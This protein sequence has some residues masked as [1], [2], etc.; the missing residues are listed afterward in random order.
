MEILKELKGGLNNFMINKNGKVGSGWKIFGFML[1][2]IVGLLIVGSI[3]GVGQTQVEK[4]EPVEDITQC[5][6]S[7]GVLTA[8]SRSAL[9]AGTDPSSPTITAGVD[10]GPVTTSVTSGTTT[11]PVGSEIEVLVSKSD[12]IDRSFTFTMP[13]GGKT[14][15]APLFYSTSDNPSIRIKNDDGDFMTDSFKGATNQTDLSVGETLILDVE[16]QGTNGESSGDGIYIIEFPASTSANITSVTLDGQSP[17]P[18]PSGLHTAQNADSELVAFNVGA[19]E[20][21]V[22]DTH[23]LSI[24]LG[25]TKDLTGGVYTDWYAKQEFIETDD[26]IAYGTVDAQGTSKYENNVGYDFYI[27]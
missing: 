21:A 27:N 12:Y 24:V 14:L 2:G 22:K 13:C 15:D 26:T 3:L 1:L 9:S 10:G 23:T 5:A 8:N 20:G 6:D 4:G 11:F 19:V 18:L 16:L 17:I 7:T 25:S